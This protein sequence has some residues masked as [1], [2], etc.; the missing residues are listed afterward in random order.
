MKAGGHN[1]PLVRKERIMD[2]NIAEECGF[3][4]DDEGVYV[5]E[6]GDQQ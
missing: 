5:S 4:N 3:V 6:E 2:C 1:C